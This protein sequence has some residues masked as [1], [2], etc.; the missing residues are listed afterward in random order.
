MNQATPIR[1][2]SV[3][4]W[5]GIPPN[6]CFN[7][8]ILS[9]RASC[10]TRSLRAPTHNQDPFFGR[11][12]ASMP[13]SITIPISTFD[14]TFVYERPVIRLL[15]DRLQVIETIFTALSPW[16]PN[17]DDMEVVTEGKLSEQGVKFKLASQRAYF[18]F[19]PTNCRFSKDAATWADFEEIERLLSTVI[20]AFRGVTNINFMSQISMLTIHLQPAEVPFRDILRKVLIKD[21]LLALDPSPTTV[22]AM[23]LRWAK[24]RVTI[25]GSAALANGIFVQM[26]RE[27]DGQATLEDIKMAIHKDEQD[28]FKILAVKEDVSA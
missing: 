1:P 8:Y 12:G 9:N 25:D 4:G 13:A 7:I 16:S 11:I 5:L 27:F 18:F 20:S 23:V 14:I 28:I 19:G 22:M 21:S 24:F 3:A 17:L 10:L 6:F 2:A 26:E 15:V